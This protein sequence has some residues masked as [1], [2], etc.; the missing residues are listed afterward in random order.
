MVRDIPI[1]TIRKRSKGLPFRGLLI[2]VLLILVTVGFFGYMLRNDP[3][4]KNIQAAFGILHEPSTGVPAESDAIGF[5]RVSE[6]QLNEKFSFA[7][8]L[9]ALEHSELQTVKGTLIYQEYLRTQ[10]EYK[11]AEIK[12]IGG[13]ISLD[14]LKQRRAAYVSATANLQGYLDSQLK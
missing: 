13:D 5:I 1:S 4:R 10:L 2:A 7:A 12:Q 14:E 6:S 9:S 8:G 3:N 11:L